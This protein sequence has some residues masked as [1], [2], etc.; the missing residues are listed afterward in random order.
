V[1]SVLS[2]CVYERERERERKGET[3]RHRETERHTQREQRTLILL[4]YQGLF[5]NPK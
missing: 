3:K 5:K 1:F 4:G 2:V